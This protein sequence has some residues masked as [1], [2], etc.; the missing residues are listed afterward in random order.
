MNT[1]LLL[2]FTFLS[3]ASFLAILFGTDPYHSAAIVIFLF[4]TTM[5]LSLMG[6][7]GLFGIAGAKLGGKEAEYGVSLR[8]ALLLSTLVTSLVLLEKY[9]VLNIGNTAALFLLT[10]GVEM[11]FVYRKINEYRLGAWKEHF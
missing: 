6:I 1:A 10:V 9:F 5:F 3:S 8:R 7:F 11:T 2:I 4:F